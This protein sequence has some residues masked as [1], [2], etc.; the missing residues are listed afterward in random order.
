MG[1]RECFQSFVMS[2]VHGITKSDKRLFH[3]AINEIG[4]DAG[5]IIFIDDS[6]RNLAVAR[7][8][9]MIPVK[10]NRYGQGKGRSTFREIGSLEE[11]LQLVE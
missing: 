8:V 2:S 9:G 5:E 6:E 3:I 7:K 11:L 4:A 10:I 1:L